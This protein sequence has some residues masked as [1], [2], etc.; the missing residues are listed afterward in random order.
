[1]RRNTLFATLACC[2]ICGFANTLVSQNDLLV[3]RPFANTIERYDG[4]SGDYLGAF[5]TAGSGGLVRPGSVAVGPDN[6]V[7]VTSSLTAQVLRYDGKTGKFIDVFA[8]GNGL[9][10]PNNLVFRGDYLYVGDFSGGANGFLRRFDAK[11]GAFVDNFAD[12]DFADGIA[13]SSDSVFVS[14][15]INGDVERFNLNDGSFIE[16]FVRS[17]N[18]GLTNP[19]ALLFL[20]SGELL[21]SSYSTDSVKRYSTDGEYIDDVITDLFEPEGLAIGLDGNLYAGSYGLGLT[22]KYDIN[23]F[24]FIEEFTNTGPVTN[25]FTFRNTLLGDMNQDGEV[26]LL[27]VAP[28]VDAIS[29][30]NFQAEADINQDGTVDLLDVAPFVDILIG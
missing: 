24:Q 20:E 4:I 17:G 23:T 25:F 14:N 21:V 30:G 7:Y 26:N 28:F 6:N 27:D 12:V 29:G 16:T 22:N 9:T 15:F 18:G 11:T 10:A 13:F 5:V 1:M 3:T 8:S 19:T 2:V